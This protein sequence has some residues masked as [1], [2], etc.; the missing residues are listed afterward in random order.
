M[1]GDLF[2]D[3]VCPYFSIPT[4]VPFFSLF[5]HTFFIFLSHT[6]L[7]LSLFLQYNCHYDVI[8]SADST[9]MLEYWSGSTYSFPKAVKFESKLD[10]DLY[11]FIKVYNQVISATSLPD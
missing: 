2:S 10:T 7:P 5:I 1:Y 3:L 9:G 8:V 11:E 4:L 6:S